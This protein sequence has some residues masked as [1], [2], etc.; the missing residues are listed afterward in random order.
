LKRLPRENQGLADMIASLLAVPDEIENASANLITG[1][2]LIRFDASRV[3][4]EELLGYLRGMF[5][6]FMRNRERFE[7]LAPERMPEVIGRLKSV[8]RSAVG[9]RLRVNEETVI[10]DHVLA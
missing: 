9:P 5:E 8:V 2:V 3:T 10:E 1:N 6:I 7:G 4:E